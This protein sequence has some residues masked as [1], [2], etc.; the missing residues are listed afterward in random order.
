MPDYDFAQHQATANT[1]RGLSMDGVQAAN[2]GH[3]GMPMGMADVATV[4]WSRYLKHDPR[5]PQWPDRDRFVLSAG[6]GS[7]L[8]YSLLH[9]SDYAGMPMAELQQFRQWGSNTPGHPELG[10]S[11]GV[12]MTTGPLG[13]GISSGVGMALAERMLAERFNKPDFAVVDHFTYVIAGDGDLMEGVSHEACSLAGHLGLGKLIVFYDDNAIT[14]D[15]S[16]GIAFTEDTLLRFQAY[17][18][19]T[20]LID[21]HDP[22]AIIAATEIAQAETERPSIIACRTKIGFGSP[23]KEGTAGAHGEPLGEEEIR[24]TKARLGLPVD[25]KFFVAEGAKA[26]LAREGAEYAAW[27]R[28]WHAYAQAF[29]TAAIAYQDALAGKLPTNWDEILPH[30]EAGKVAGTRVFSGQVINALAPHMPTLLG[31]S[32]DL[33]G[34]NK[35]GISGTEDVQRDAFGGRYIRYGV[36]EHG[37]GAIMNG[38]SLHGGFRPYGGTFLVF[39]DY[40]RGAIRL[41]AIMGLP[42]IYVF[43]HDGIGVGEDGPTHQPIE[44]LMSLRIIPNLTVIRPADGTETAFAWRA[45]L[46]NEDGPTAL[47]FSRQGVPELE[48]SDERA[49]RGGYVVRDVDEPQAILIGT[50]TELHIALQAQELLALRGVAARVVSLPSWELFA[51]QSPEYVDSVLPPGISARVSVEAGVTSGWQR[52]TGDQGV[53]IGL[54][55]FGASAP[56]QVV[57][58]E[59]GITA[60]AVATAAEALLEMEA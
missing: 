29:P 54:D 32:A 58:Q 12:E 20:E 1:I 11:P 52:Y 47:V 14:I 43:T 5:H 40:M 30:F 33:T 2:S 60:E 31:G 21:G 15:G 46:E 27:Q 25:E 17:G 8:L 7:M 44:Q 22:S 19:H 57:Y 18:W 24:L 50:G 6:H 10:H 13:Q 55:R 3:P 23:H 34:S 56:Y 59:L 42:V 48:E 53:A 38:I 28:L 49:L 51:Q 26:F 41:A 36:R 9:L 35:T 4:L 16:T 45:A 39:S 37:M